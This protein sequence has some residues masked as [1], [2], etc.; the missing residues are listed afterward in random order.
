[1]ARVWDM[2][3]RQQIA[4]LE[5]HTNTVYSVLMQENEE[6]KNSLIYIEINKK[7]ID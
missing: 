7:T 4:C 6:N 1:V 5:G 3:S 2:R